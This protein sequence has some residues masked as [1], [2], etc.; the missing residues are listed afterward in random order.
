[1]V[2]TPSGTSLR[3]CGR[4]NVPEPVGGEHGVLAANAISSEKGD[5]IPRRYLTK[6]AIALKAHSRYS[7]SRGQSTDQITPRKHGTR[8]DSCRSQVSYYK[9]YLIPF[10]HMYCEKWKGGRTTRHHSDAVRR[11]NRFI[12]LFLRDNCASL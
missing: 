9:R 1:M 10:L 4:Q 8:K 12:L 5:N 7:R 3:F 2:T 11:V 6:V